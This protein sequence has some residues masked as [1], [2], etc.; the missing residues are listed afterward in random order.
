M[1]G[2]FGTLW[3]RVAARFFGYLLVLALLV[4]FL[5]VDVAF[6]AFFGWFGAVVYRHVREAHDAERRARDAERKARDAA[7]GRARA[8]RELDNLREE[9]M[10][11]AAFASTLADEIERLRGVV[12]AHERAQRASSG[13]S[14]TQSSRPSGGPWQQQRSYT[15]DE[16]K[17]YGIL[18]LTPGASEATIRAAY[19]RLIME[20]HPDRGGS[21]ERAQDINWAKNVLLKKSAA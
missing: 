1:E 17:A 13:A 3:V 10:R 4:G 15:A 21:I 11:F 14:G 9:G 2:F 18:K 7:Q 20:A 8:I 16:R 19:R 6:W 12:Q 5:P